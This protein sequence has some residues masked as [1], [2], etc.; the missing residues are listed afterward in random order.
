[1]SDRLAIVGST[2]FAD[3]RAWDVARDIIAGVFERRLPDQ[4]ISGGAKGIDSLAAESARRHGVEVVEHL[5]ENP[6]W[7]PDGYR[8]RNDLIADGCTR[9]LRIT[10]RWSRTYGSGYTMD[11]AR[12]RGVLCWS[13][14][15]PTNLLAGQLKVETAAGVVPLPVR[16]GR[17]VGPPAYARKLGW[18]ET[19]ADAFV[20]RMTKAAY[21]VRWVP[22]QVPGSAG[23]R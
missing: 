5:P 10:C 4:V 11:R 20:Q 9:L 21:R 16:D 19:D 23:S 12:A 1:M 8:K 2:R 3:V 7:E 15:L 17:I 13:L 22:D 18:T 14:C 6:R